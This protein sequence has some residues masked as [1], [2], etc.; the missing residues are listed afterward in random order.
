MERIGVVINPSFN[1]WP[2]FLEKMER[3]QAQMFSLGWVADYP[4]A[5]NYLQLFFGPNSSPGPNHCN[6]VNPEFD[7]LYER[8]REMPDG[9]ERTALYQ[10]M[11]DIIVEDCP[12]I[13][14][15]NWMAFSLNHSWVKNFKYH[16]F[17]YGMVKYYRI[18][19]DV[20]T[21]WK[22]RYGK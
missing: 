4:D 3:R 10:Q 15:S 17:P 16:D 22:Q 13:F 5:E 19:T 9:P 21:D 1:N 11:A 2:T 7:R 12:W 18:D 8:A 14:M 6:Y 20:R